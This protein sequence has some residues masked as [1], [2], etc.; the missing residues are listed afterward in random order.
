[1]ILI[2]EI[3]ESIKSSVIEL[4][5]GKEK[6][7]FIEGVFLQSEIKNHNGRLYP[8]SIMEAEVNRYTNEYITKNKAYGELGHP[9]TPSINLD[10]V[11]HI[12]KSLKRDGNNYIG[13]AQILDT[14]MGQ[15][16]KGLLK[17][18]AN[19]GVSSRAL[20]SLKMNNE[21]INIVQSDFIL[22]TAADIVSDPSGPD[23]FV[24]GIMENAEWIYDANTTSWRMAEFIKESIKTDTTKQLAEKQAKYFQDFLKSIR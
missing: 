13:K 11:S 20:G 2:T 14:P 4:N 17:G 6:Q 3:N 23:C 7:Y 1:M 16:A 5:E 19:L 10:R 9:N 22:R 21:G 8:M 12:I 15:I 18:G 24:Q